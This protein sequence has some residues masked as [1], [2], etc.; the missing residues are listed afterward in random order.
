MIHFLGLPDIHHKKRGP[1]PVIKHKKRTSAKT[2][3]KKKDTSMVTVL[4]N[5]SP[6]RFSASIL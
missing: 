1:F 3:F 4:L 2:K 5:R 6:Q